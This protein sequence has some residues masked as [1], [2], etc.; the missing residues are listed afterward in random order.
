MRWEGDLASVG[1]DGLA[2]TTQRSPALR[3][4]VTLLCMMLL[5]GL[6]ACGPFGETGTAP[7]TAAT[8]EPTREGIAFAEPTATP[9]VAP[10]ATPHTD[11]SQPFTLTI[12]TPPD[13]AA[14][15]EEGGEGL[16]EQARRRVAASWPKAS[17]EVLPKAPDGP[18]GIP[19]LLTV[20][21]PVLP[22]YLPDAV[23]VDATEIRGLVEQGLAVPLEALVS[24][25]LWDDLYPFARQA[26]TVDGVLYGLPQDAD[27]T[28]MY[29]NS[30]MVAEPPGDWAT[31]LE[32]S[33][34]YLFPVLA[35]DD[36][37]YRLFLGHYTALGGAFRDAGG[38]PMLDATVAARVL[39]GYR[40]LVDADAIPQGGLSLDS[41]DT[42]WAVYLTGESAVSSARSYQYLRDRERVRLTRYA[43][44]ASFGGPAPAVAN[45]RAWVIVTN[46]ATRQEVAGQFIS[47]CL[48]P[49]R[50][51]TW[52]AD[53]YYLPTT[54]SALPLLIDD[55]DER[56]FWDG[57]LE[58]AV[59]TPD[60]DVNAR[61]RH[62]VERALVDVLEGS[63]S[64]EQAAVTAALAAE[65]AP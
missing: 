38:Q 37:A 28:T 46:D 11:A 52:L 53:S 3:A 6:A 61:I 49:A 26:V 21:Q 17:I 22:A 34:G 44:Q 36:T 7:T 19:R 16:L 51:A 42:C 4:V 41:A 63:A 30:G 31:L 33:G 12:W 54:R 2:H 47:Q 29:Y 35:G 1:G 27:L 43:P 18:G 9:T 56:A 55:E 60:A 14:T 13:V 20:M 45:V 59:P 64:P 57:Q 8:T 50:A 39:R 48:L 10:T 25:S 15:A 62:L 40:E 5:F 24:E 23:L 58:A 65:S 32:T